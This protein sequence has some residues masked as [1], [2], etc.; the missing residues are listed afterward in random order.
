MI[1]RSLKTAEA[2]ERSSWIGSLSLMHSQPHF[3]WYRSIGPPNPRITLNLRSLP[4]STREQP[5][6]PGLRPE[7]PAL[8]SISLLPKTLTIQSGKKASSA[9]ARCFTQMTFPL[10]YTL[11][12]LLESGNQ[13]PQ[14]LTP[15]WQSSTPPSRYS[16]IQRT[17]WG[18]GGRRWRAGPS[19]DFKASVVKTKSQT[20]CVRS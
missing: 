9:S 19:H 18:G 4:S 17:M 11:P 13:A 15:T 3:I 1:T 7:K 14:D 6:V 5:L 20:V 10:S 12:I 8:W 2:K 16:P